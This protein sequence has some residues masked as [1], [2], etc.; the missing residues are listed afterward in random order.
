[1][2][3][4]SLKMRQAW[5]VSI[6]TMP[7]NRQVLPLAI[8]ILSAFRMTRTGTLPTRIAEW[9]TLLTCSRFLVS[10]RLLSRWQNQLEYFLYQF[11][12]THA[13]QIL[14]DCHWSC[15]EAA[16]LTQ[17]TEKFTEFFCFHNKPVF[18]NHGVSEEERESFCTK[19]QRVRRIRNFAVHRVNP[20]VYTIRKYANDALDV[21]RIVQRLGNEAFRRSFESPVSLKLICLA[22]VSLED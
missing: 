9:H 18:R 16:E 20:S 11:C 10:Y 22:K 5:Y 17:L 13:P 3:R 6:H 2:D 21:L 8:M 7:W 4:N 12:K 19:L 14:V 1:M 15:P